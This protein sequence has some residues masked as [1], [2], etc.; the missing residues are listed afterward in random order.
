M[1]VLGSIDPDDII[2]LVEEGKCRV[3]YTQT[4]YSHTDTNNDYVYTG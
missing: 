4:D 2:V 1:N 3:V